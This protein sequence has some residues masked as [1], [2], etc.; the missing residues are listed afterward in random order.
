MAQNDVPLW[1]DDGSLGFSPQREPEVQPAAPRPGP[2]SPPVTQNIETETQESAASFG[3][4][5]IGIGLAQGF[6][7]YALFRTRADGIWPGNDA[8]LFDA[9]ALPLLFLPWSVM[10][11]LGRIALPRLIAFAAIAAAILATLGWYHR[12][13]ITGVASGQPGLSMLVLAGLALFIA[14]SFLEAWK[15][16]RIAYPDFF[17]AGWTLAARS[18]LL[19]L[20]LGIGV[21]LTTLLP[22]LSLERG[23]IVAM[24]LL[25]LC[26][27]LVLQLTARFA[28]ALCQGAIATATALLPLTVAA[29]IIL[30]CAGLV[31]TPPPLA[32]FVVLRGGVVLSIGASGRDGAP[33]PLWREG[34]EMIGAPLLLALGALAV[35][36]LAQRVAALG[37]T[38]PRFFAASALGL[39]CAYGIGT[40]IAAIIGLVRGHGLKG[41]GLINMTLAAV[42]LTGLL[43]LASPLADPLR[44]APQT[45]AARLE[46]GRVAVERFDFANLPRDGARFGNETL[47]ALS[48][49]LYPDIARAATE[50]Q[51]GM[52]AGPPLNPTEIGANIAVRTPGARLPA[53]LLARDWSQ[54]AGAPPCLATAKEACEAFFLDL[55]G[56]HRPEILLV[57]GS[58]TRWWAAVMEEDAAGRWRLAG[59]LAAGCGA[60][61]SDL[62][63]GRF[64]GLAAL[65]GWDDLQVAGARLS[66]TPSGTGCSHY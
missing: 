40:S 1:V 54:V 66:V 59:R 45:Q 27:A 30:L 13:R 36:I 43:A 25:G 42:A 15:S 2:W 46:G 37:W 9:I 12:W 57:T 32:A 61:L 16:G 4:W 60:S 39:L 11:G 34:L 7:F 52:R 20:T 33:R 44:L 22:R 65:P 56:D 58:E 23:D 26:G 47:T 29:A 50:A 24:P 48:H 64:S 41:I 14:Q 62:R 3:F 31:G 8:F 35:W 55:N 6:L 63:A 5:R 51:G 19:L 21:A 10:A 38:S 28:A 49:S 53:T 18:S 17:A